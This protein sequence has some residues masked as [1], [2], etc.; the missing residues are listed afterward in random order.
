MPTSV[1]KQKR[2]HGITWTL[3]NYEPYIDHLKQ[4]AVSECDYMIFG[5]ETCPDT[6][7]KHLQGYHH[8]SNARTYPNKKWRDVTDLETNGRDFI[9]NGSPQQNYDYCSKLGQFW[10]HG[11]LPKQGA[12]ADWQQAVNDLQDG[13]AIHTVVL[14]QPQLL[15]CIRAL[16][17]FQ[18]ISNQ[19]INR[20]VHVIVLIGESGTGKTRWAYDTYPDLYSKPEGNWW[21]GYTGQ[22]TILLDDYYGDIHHSQLLKILDRY[23]LTVPVKCGFVNAQWTTVIITSNRHPRS[24]YPAEPN[25]IALTR[26]IN[27]LVEEYTHASQISS[28]APPPSP[29]S[30]P[31]P[32]PPGPPQV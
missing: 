5:F 15:P 32:C 19:P 14:T 31:P 27:L 16:E 13:H 24:W 25:I 23:P 9:S 11:E 7:K 12:R 4:Y 17:R 28:Q 29:C 2:T 3:F 21:D 10:E 30:P 8:Y 18:Q 20:P 26:R 1:L 6:G 22:K